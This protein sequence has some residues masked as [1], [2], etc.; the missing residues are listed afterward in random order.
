MLAAL[1][2]CSPTPASPACESDAPCRATGAWCVQ[3][4]C[5]QCRA[6]SDCERGARCVGGRCLRG[7]QGCEGDGDCLPSHR[8]LDR[9]CAPRPECDEARPCSVGRR[10][11]LGACVAE[12][13]DAPRFT[14]DLGEC[15]LE[16][17][18]FAYNDSSL[19]ELARRALERGAACALRVPEARLLVVGRGD[20]RGTPESNRALAAQRAATVIRFMTALGVPD[21]RFEATA[22]EGSVGADES[23][24][25]FD[26]RVDFERLPDAPRRSRR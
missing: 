6:S 9:R 18:Y 15:S 3:G 14:L 23:T 11:E 7:E 24:W 25:R 2:A 12:A 5:S 1:L 21:D 4:R 8:C 17:P 22:R 20:P 26:R 19:D 16:S 13:E 10:C